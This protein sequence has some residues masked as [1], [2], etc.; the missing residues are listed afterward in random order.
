M[1]SLPHRKDSFRTFH[2]YTL[3]NASENLFM[4]LKVLGHSRYSRLTCLD[5]K[6]QPRAGEKNCG[7][8]GGGGGV[9]CEPHASY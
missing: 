3:S 7:G 5:G 6:P 4:A 1:R 2:H 9:G 8:G